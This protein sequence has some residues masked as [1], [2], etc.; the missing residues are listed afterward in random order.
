[1]TSITHEHELAAFMTPLVHFLTVLQ[2]PL[3]R[4]LHQTQQQRQPGIPTLESFPHFL[5]IRL[6]RAHQ[7]W[8][9][10]RTS[11][12]DVVQ[13]TTLEEVANDVR[14]GTWFDILN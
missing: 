14:V 11:Q 1:M 8:Q 9:V 2:P 5:Q 13:S 12:N 4:L 6:L 7:L 3:A 10:V